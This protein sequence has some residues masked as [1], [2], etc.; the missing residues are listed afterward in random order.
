VAGNHNGIVSCAFNR[1]VGPFDC[2]IDVATVLII[3]K[4]VAA[5]PERIAQS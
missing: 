3:N 1:F 2:A 4:W 5:I